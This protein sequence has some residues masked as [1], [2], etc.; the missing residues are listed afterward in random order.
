MSELHA[1]VGLASLAGVEDHINRRNE[2]VERF[3]EGTASVPGLRILRPAVGDRTTY[4]DLT[5]SVDRETFGLDA[6]TL[7]AALATDGIDSRRYYHPPVH[8]QAAYAGIAPTDLPETDALADAVLSPPLWSHL[9]DDQL[10]RI[11]QA[12]MR[13]QEHAPAVADALRATGKATDTLM[14]GN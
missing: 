11:A 13:I 4:K 6:A 7:Q 5:I 9:S 1:A 3:A 10:D 12:I 8:R 2:L 14:A